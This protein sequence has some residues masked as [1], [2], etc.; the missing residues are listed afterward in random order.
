M[1]I[2]DIVLL[3]HT[4]ATIAMGGVIW[5]V[6]VVH[7]PLFERVGPSGFAE[8]EF[9]HSRLTSIVVAP[10]MIVEAATA[11]VLLFWLPGQTLLWWGIGV[12][13][14]IWVSTFV[15]QVPQHRRLAEGFDASAHRRLV[16]TNWLRT[17]GWSARGVIALALL[18]IEF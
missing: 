9:A 12:L 16:L 5:F 15:L 14:L 7:Y 3:L 4:A 11:V 13:V 1:N 10:L 8:Y 2:L 6:Q 18:I 17:I